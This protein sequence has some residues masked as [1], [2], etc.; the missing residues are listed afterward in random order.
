MQWRAPRRAGSSPRGRGTRSRRYAFASEIRF[1]PARAG[2]ASGAAKTTRSRAVHPRAGGERTKPLA[3]FFDGFGSSPRGRGTLE[4]I[5]GHVAGEQFIPARAGNAILNAKVIFN[6]PVHPRAGG[7]RGGGAS[8]TIACPGSSPRGRG[9]PSG[10][11]SSRP[12]RRFIP[13]RAGNAASASATSLSAAVHPRAGGERMRVEFAG[14]DRS[15]SSPRGRGTRGERFRPRRRNRFIPARA[16]NAQESS[17]N[18][19]SKTVHPRAGGERCAGVIGTVKAAGS[20]P[21]GR[22]T[23]L[24][25]EFDDLPPRFIPAR[26]GNATGPPWS[27]ALSTVHPRA[28][29]E[30]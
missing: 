2:N 12:P 4:Q 1:I 6:R 13:A 18:G 30:R 11:S 20:S 7:E 17:P 29:G 8:A 21:R 3:A 26:A 9:T 24:G 27:M 16:G 28:G 22:G 5:L 15:G 14:V 10:P 25:A 19:R 23:R